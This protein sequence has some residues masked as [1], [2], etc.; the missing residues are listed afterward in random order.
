MANLMRAQEKPPFGWYPKWAD[1]QEQVYRDNEEKKE[2]TG[3]RWVKTLIREIMS[4][5]E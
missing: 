5:I 3:G 4:Q 2:L 1:V